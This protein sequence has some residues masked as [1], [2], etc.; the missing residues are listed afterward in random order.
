MH[1]LPNRSRRDTCPYQRNA[2]AK[3]KHVTL[4]KTCD[5]TIP[6][7]SAASAIVHQKSFISPPGLNTCPY[8]RRAVSSSPGRGVCPYTPVNAEDMHGLI[9]RRV[10][11]NAPYQR[12]VVSRFPRLRRHPPSF[13]KNRSSARQGSHVPLSS[14]GQDS[15]LTRSPLQC[16]LLAHAGQRDRN[17]HPRNSGIPWN[18]LWAC[19]CYRSRIQCP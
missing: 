17:R 6:P 4:P 14:A 2:V 12:H 7:P 3:A 16:R 18:R 1:G 5:I 8:L 19:A 15:A 13:I 11:A 9:K 10:E